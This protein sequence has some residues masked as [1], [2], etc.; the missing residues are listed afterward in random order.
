MLDGKRQKEI[1]TFFEELENQTGINE[2]AQIY[3]RSKELLEISNR[4][5]EVTK[6]KI[7]VSVTNNTGTEE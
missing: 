7:I 4:Y 5:L 2:L 1:E 3:N 6:P